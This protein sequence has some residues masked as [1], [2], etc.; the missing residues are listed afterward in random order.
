[1]PIINLADPLYLFLRPE[2]LCHPMIPAAL[3]NV[4]PR[5]IMGQ[6]WWDIKRREAY[7][8]NNGCCWVC[9]ANELLDAHE[10]YEIDYLK[11]TSIFKEIVALCK[12]CH[13]FIH[14]GHTSIMLANGLI[15]YA[16]VKRIITKGL[17]IL[18][19]NN[20]EI[21]MNTIVLLGEI[22]TYAE[23]YEKKYEWIDLVSDIRIMQTEFI[24][25]LVPWNK[26]RMI[27]DGKEYPP[28]FN[29]PE[30][31]AIHYQVEKARKK[32]E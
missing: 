31:S 3:A 20:L 13:Q 6:E 17:K 7:R 14:L 27:F 23:F 19:K 16:D 26:W 5:E 28:K 24:G 11:G 29:S 18:K 8:G 25:T 10:V 1:M 21:R 15:N 22:R 4:A 9:G 12:D 30:A 32:Y 2:L